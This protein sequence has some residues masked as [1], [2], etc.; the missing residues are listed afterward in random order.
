MGAVDSLLLLLPEIKL[1]G[2]DG[3]MPSGIFEP[4]AASTVCLHD[5]M[6]GDVTL[7]DGADGQFHGNAFHR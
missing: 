1:I 5:V 2:A 6:S 3:M 7:T 4:V